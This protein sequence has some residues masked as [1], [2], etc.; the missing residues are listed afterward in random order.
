MLYRDIA[1]LKDYVL[2]DS[3]S[4][5]I[6]VFSINKSNL[7]ELKEYKHLS[8]ELVINSIDFFLTLQE[9]YEGTKLS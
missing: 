9:I 4:E 5:H 2:I 6:E 1:S 3:Q 7:W 8:D